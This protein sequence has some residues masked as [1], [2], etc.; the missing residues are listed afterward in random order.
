MRTLDLVR[1]SALDMPIVVVTGIP[2]EDFFAD[3]LDHGA[4]EV[5]A[6]EDLRTKAL[7][8]AIRYA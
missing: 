2:D 3:L 1:T 8:R 6:K 7:L 4:H 5:L